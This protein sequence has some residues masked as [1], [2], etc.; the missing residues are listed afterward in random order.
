MVRA[1]GGE[2]RGAR[3][4]ESRGRLR[5]RRPRGLY[6]ARRTDSLR[7]GVPRAPERSIQQPLQLNLPSLR[8]QLLRRQ[9]VGME[10]LA[11]SRA[12]R[13]EAAVAFLLGCVFAQVA[14]A[15]GEWHLTPAANRECLP[16]DGGEISDLP[17]ASPVPGL[18][19]LSIFTKHARNVTGHTATPP[20][21][22]LRCAM[23]ILKPYNLTW[24]ST[25]FKTI[26]EWEP[27]PINHYYTVQISTRLGDW[28]NKCFRTTETECDL[29]DEIMKDVRQTYIARVLSYQAGNGHAAGSYVEPP[30]TNSPEFIPYIETNLGQPEIKSFEQ[31]GTKLNVTVQ[32]ARTLVRANGT[33]LS[34]RD[35][36]GKNLSYV[37]YFWK[38]SSTGKKTDK[39]ETNVFLVDVDKGEDY[40]FSVQAVIASRKENQRSPESPVLCTSQGKDNFKELFFI[41]GAVVLLVIIFVIALFLSLYKCKKCPGSLRLTSCSPKQVK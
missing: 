27:K 19:K 31:V 33:F 1:R 11:G 18:G 22:M 6:I 40:C 29:T 8:S 39:T 2:S 25:N 23:D 10:P 28:K 15:A 20:L 32:D 14:G 30:F 35:I 9:F 38:S 34:L 36:F 41:I 5:R 21:A 12:A 16:W 13:P 17:E 26:L 37:L 3:G 7:L 24:K 4:R